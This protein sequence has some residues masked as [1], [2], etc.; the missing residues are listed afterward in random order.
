MDDINNLKENIDHINANFEKNI[1]MARLKED[2]KRTF[3]DY[4]K[5]MKFMAADAPIQILCLDRKLETILLDQ[6]FLRIYD[7]FNADLV[8]VKGIGVIRAKEL[9]AR[10]DQFFSML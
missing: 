7:L 4:E 3:N 10:L 6:G 2:L 5:T 1:D 9:T 8:K